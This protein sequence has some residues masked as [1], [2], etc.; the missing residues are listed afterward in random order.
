ML[1]S[2]TQRDGTAIVF[3]HIVKTAGTTLHRIIERHYRGE[4]DYFIR[5][6]NHLFADF[7]ELTIEEKARLRMIRGHMIFGIHEHLPQ[8]ATYFTLL[9]DPVARTISYYHHIRRSPDHHAHEAIVSRDLNPK[10][11]IESGVDLLLTNGQTRVLA[12]GKW[13]NECTPDAL[14]AAIHNLQEHFSVVGLVER[15]DETLLL[16]RRAFGWQNLF[17]VPQNV[18]QRR[19]RREELPPEVLS[20]ESSA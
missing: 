13:H 6:P 14:G 9:R 2:R 18:G 15:F 8:P 12:G 4:E 7:L 1:T 19:P 16:L 10:E 17:Y 3:L 5:E 11:A 20:A